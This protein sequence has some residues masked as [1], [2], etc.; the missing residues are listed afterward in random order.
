ML[1]YTLDDAADLLSKNMETAK[2]QEI[3]LE[4]DLDFLRYE[5]LFSN[6]GSSLKLLLGL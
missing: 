4:E 5:I 2:K 3:V 1:E 6:S